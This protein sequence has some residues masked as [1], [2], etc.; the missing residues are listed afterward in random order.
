[1]SR[2][3]GESRGSARAC[4]PP[5]SPT[6]LASW[7]LGD[8]RFRR[9]CRPRR[10]WAADGR[11]AGG[12][13]LRGRRAC[14]AIRSVRSW[15]G[16]L[17]DLTGEPPGATATGLVRRGQ[18]SECG[19][20]RTR[21]H[22]RGDVGRAPGLAS[23]GLPPHGEQAR[24]VLAQPDR[25]GV[26]GRGDAEKGRRR[27]TPLRPTRRGR[28][29]TL[30]L[31]CARSPGSARGRR[32]RRAFAYSSAP[33]GPP[34]PASGHVGRTPPNYSGRVR[35]APGGPPVGQRNGAA[36]GGWR[37]PHRRAAPMTKTF[38]VSPPW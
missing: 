33:F 15:L 5:L 32:P 20:G 21:A 23:E 17:P 2:G 7:A 14:P 16:R 18:A 1:M 31:E 37:P 22:R 8:T 35:T 13:R 9:V 30:L 10:P 6:C 34:R 4:G 36:A 24:L 29:R 3:D 27:R 26:G 25:Q 38:R 11:R 12:G 28:R 19:E